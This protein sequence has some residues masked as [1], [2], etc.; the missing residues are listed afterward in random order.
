MKNRRV[1]VSPCCNFLNR[2]K[3]FV[4]TGRLCPGTF[5]ERIVRPVAEILGSRRDERYEGACLNPV[6]SGGA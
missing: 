3:L 5:L 1:N 4:R 2:A 6:C